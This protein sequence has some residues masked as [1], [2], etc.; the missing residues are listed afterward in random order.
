M[1]ASSVP[2]QALV[3]QNSIGY[4]VTCTN[5]IQFDLLVD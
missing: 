4:S 2:T 3:S 1:V 5:V